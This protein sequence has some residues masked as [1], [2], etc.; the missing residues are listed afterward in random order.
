MN[1]D[2]K[3]IKQFFVTASIGF[4]FLVVSSLVWNIQNEKKTTYK[5]AKVEATGNQNKDLTWRRW[6]TLHGGVY[7]PITDKIQPNNYLNFVPKR[8]VTTTD[9]QKLTLIN[10][11]YM[12]R[13]AHELELEISGEIGHITS[14]N[15][16]RPE[17]K[18][19]E[20]ET[21]ALKQ[22]ES[23][24]KEHCSIETINGK[25]YLR[26]MR[27]MYVE[28]GCLKCH[29]NQ[30][31]QLG[32]IRGGFS[33]AIPMDKYETIIKAKISDLVFFHIFILAIGLFLG[34]LAYRRT[35]HSVKE[36]NESQEIIR[37]NE[38]LLKIQNKE[39]RKSKEKAEE[40]DRLKTIFLQNMSH[41][42]RTPMNAILGFSSLIP[43]EF[44]DKEKL[45]EYT[46]IINQ[47]GKDLLCIINDL[48][49]ISKIESEKVELH[50]EQFNLNTLLNEV[51]G[52]ALAL[53]SRFEKFHINVMFPLSFDSDNIILCSDKG[54]LKQVFA[55]LI[56]NA[57][58]FTLEGKITIGYHLSANKIYFH[59]EDTGIGIPEKELDNVF[60]R[61]TQV[62]QETTRI[63]DG[64]G[65]GLSIAKGIIK[66][67]NGQ[68]GVESE[69]NKGSKFTFYIP[70]EEVDSAKGQ[71][72]QLQFEA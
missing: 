65:L 6:A 43:G 7:V 40:S 34:W 59:V 10:P 13:L 60:N 50:I 16:I 29:A 68:I 5:L 58:K 14:L 49:D 64:T 30:G 42:I 51:K 27:P 32:D 67:L 28:K 20:W 22:F 63:H 12:T 48:L 69:V 1:K 19:D 56:S 15:P 53:Q 17:N 18:A 35:L 54:R 45:T 31:Y 38:K 47:R 8:D 2:I 44:H 11:A 62:E 21:N 36:R 26:Y 70:F 25:E 37:K 52:V 71:Q 66:L 24:A 41:E 33:V 55:N 57:F 3:H 23:G 46:N 4:V 39:L 61:F 72:Q 9:G